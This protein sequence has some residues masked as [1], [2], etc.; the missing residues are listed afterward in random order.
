VEKE[1]KITSKIGA[2]VHGERLPNNEQLN[3]M[4]PPQGIVVI[5]SVIRSMN[6]LDGYT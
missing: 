5:T 3:M 4:N 6:S 1:S 2:S